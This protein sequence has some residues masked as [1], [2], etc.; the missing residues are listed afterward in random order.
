MGLSATIVAE[1]WMMSESAA[2]KTPAF[3]GGPHKP[4]AF[5]DLLRLCGPMNTLHVPEAIAIQTASY[6][7]PSSIISAL[8]SVIL[9]RN[10]VIAV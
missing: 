9:R 7:A 1:Y 5:I 3:Q 2:A 6:V 10:L 4:A 8:W